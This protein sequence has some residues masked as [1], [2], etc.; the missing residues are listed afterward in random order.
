MRVMKDGFKRGT[1]YCHRQRMAGG[2]GC[3][4]AD[5]DRRID[6]PFGDRD[7]LGECRVARCGRVA[8]EH[9]LERTTRLFC[10]LRVLHLESIRAQTWRR[11]RPKAEH[12]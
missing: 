12:Q 1:N 9:D 2:Y 8:S 7:Y 11:R 5:G 4:P 6:G 3:G 10:E